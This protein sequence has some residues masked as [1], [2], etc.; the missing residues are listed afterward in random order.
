MKQRRII[1][2]FIATA[3]AAGLSAGCDSNKK[4]YEDA[5]ALFDS[6]QYEAAA[7]FEA[8]GEY[9]DAVELAA[10]AGNEAKYTEAAAAFEALGSFKD[11]TERAEEALEAITDLEYQAANALFEQGDYAEAAAAYSNHNT[12]RKFC[13]VG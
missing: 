1:A 6:G 8:L 12:N 5:K 3:L 4:P 11:A 2:L 9:E 10:E 13:V 7:A